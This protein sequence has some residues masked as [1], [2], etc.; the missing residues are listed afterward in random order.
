MSYTESHS[1][2]AFH[3][4]WWAYLTDVLETGLCFGLYFYFSLPYKLHWK[5]ICSVYS[6]PTPICTIKGYICCE[7]LKHLCTFEMSSFSNP[8]P[9]HWFSPVQRI[10][11]T[12]GIT[13]VFQTFPCAHVNVCWHCTEMQTYL[14]TATLIYLQ[15]SVVL[16]YG[17]SLYSMAGN[18]LDTHFGKQWRH[19]SQGWISLKWL[20][21]SHAHIDLM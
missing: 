15:K 14:S 18:S 19:L 16:S 21:I 7:C 8:P 6:F 20:L 12:E 11:N 9:I 13:S 1:P 10:N 17:D 2:I 4:R 3:R 5:K